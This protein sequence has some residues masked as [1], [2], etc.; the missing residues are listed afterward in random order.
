[1]S[2][3]EILSSRQ[4]SGDQH[5]L[6]DVLQHIGVI[7]NKAIES[8][9]GEVNTVLLGQVIS[10]LSVFSSRMAEKEFEFDLSAELSKLVKKCHIAHENKPQRHSFS[11]I[12]A[13]LTA[14]AENAPPACSLRV[15]AQWEHS[16]VHSSTFISAI[17]AAL[18]SGARDGVR[19]ELS[20]SMLRIQR[21][22]DEGRRP[23]T[24]NGVMVWS[25]V[26]VEGEVE[27]RGSI[28]S[29]VLEG[30]VAISK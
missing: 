12:D 29:R 15:L 26:P 16:C 9:E 25:G 3:N 30:T 27:D 24:E 8:S 11:N 1:M 7:S 18:I 10:F 19:G 17:H 4:Y 13:C 22:R 5:V 20:G 23:M 6:C 2:A 14:I 28:W 21:A